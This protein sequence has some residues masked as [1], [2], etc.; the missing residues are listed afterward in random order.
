MT[1]VSSKFALTSIADLYEQ[2]KL[3]IGVTLFRPM[4]LMIP[5]SC[6]AVN[7][8]GFRNGRTN[9]G[10]SGQIAAIVPVVKRSTVKT[11]HLPEK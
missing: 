10:D 3:Q 7:Q 4:L 6:P 11:R 1:G 9:T 2:C 5:Y 8:L